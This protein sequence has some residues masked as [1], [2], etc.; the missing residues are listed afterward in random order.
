MGLAA[1]SDAMTATMPN[2]QTDQQSGLT[3]AP[4]SITNAAPII[5]VWYGLNQSFGSL[6]HPQNWIDILGNVTDP[7]NDRITLTYQLN[8]GPTLAGFV[9]EGRRRDR[10]LAEKGD[11]IIQ[12]DR[13]QF[14]DGLNTV[15]IT[16]SDGNGGQ[17]TTTVNVNYQAS[18]V[19]PLP[20][21]IDWTKVSQQTLQQVVQIVDGKWVVGPTGIRPS[22]M[23]Y[24]RIIAL[25]DI[26]WQDYEV[27]VP[28]MLNAFNPDGF[29]PVSVA[30]GFGIV[31][32]WQ[33]HTAS[34]HCLPPMPVCYWYPQGATFWAAI[35]P[36]TANMAARMNP[37][38]PKLGTMADGT[39][40]VDFNTWY[41]WKAQVETINST[42][43][44]YRFRYWKAGDPEPTTWLMEI[45][46]RADDPR[47]LNTGS[48]LL[49][50]HQVDATFGNVAVKPLGGTMPTPT[51]TT[52]ATASPTP[53]ATATPLPTQTSTLSPTATN[54]PGPTPTATATPTATVSP[55]P[56]LEPDDHFI[57]FP[58]VIRP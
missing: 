23:A 9:G 33:G 36:P 51:P 42:T 3:Q 4:R 19:W 5:N 18:T 30:P 41:W 52:S 34:T 13:S 10:R 47:H 15:T 6:G 26:I 32:R 20:Y 54:T 58:V 25:G 38:I 35:S 48:V 39:I 12:I 43:S 16:A 37:P 29:G 17:S 44:R 53:T 56:T 14:V 27:T 49:V 1:V 40:E 50:A 55:T 24:D 31:L 7:N 57:L 28:I 2:Q 21:S 46:K 45:D 22:V 8:S 11:F